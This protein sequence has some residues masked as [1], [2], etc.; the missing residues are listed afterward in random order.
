[1]SGSLYILTGPS[2]VGKTSVATKLLT[3]RENLKKVV[4]NTTREPREG[5][6]NGIDYHFVT[7]A[8]FEHMI[9]QDE[10]FEWAKVYDR[11]YGS[12]K[13]H[14]NALLNEGKDVLMVIDVQGAKTIQSEHIE[15]ITIFL[16]AESP[17]QLLERIER[18][19]GGETDNYEE[20]KAA[21]E[22]EMSFG[23][24]CTHTIVNKEGKLEETVAKIATIMSES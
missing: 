1:M 14:V 19:G 23:P 11:Y 6:Q 17:E 7:E 8:E 4:T 13:D 22:S 5:E 3:T 10:L 18:R 12:R 9:K 21:L 16:E 24:S 15:A 20:R 2:G